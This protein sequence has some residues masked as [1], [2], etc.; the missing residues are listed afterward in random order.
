[1][2][3]NQLVYNT[4]A[5]NLSFC[6]LGSYEKVKSVFELSDTDMEEFYMISFIKN[7]T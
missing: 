3:F 7:Y 1:M 2:Q 5:T 6:W 4:I